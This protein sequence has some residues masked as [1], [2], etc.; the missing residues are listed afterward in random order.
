MR[1]TMTTLLILGLLIG[2]FGLPA[3]A[4]KRK[5]K[6]PTRVERTEESGYQVPAIGLAGIG[7]CSGG[8]GVGC[9]LFPVQR[10]EKFAHV[11][12]QD[13]SGTEVFAQMNQDLDGDGFVDT[14]VPFCGSTDEPLAI[15]PGGTIEIWVWTGPSLDLSCTGVAT[16]GSMTVTFSNLP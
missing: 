3:E 16:T 6:K 4:A 11:E 13:A 8:P 2:A 1:R 14:S 5:K 15:E 9:A 7:Y 12:I 10:N